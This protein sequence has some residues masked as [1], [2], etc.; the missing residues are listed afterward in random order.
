M[1]KTSFFKNHSH[2]ILLT[3]NQNKYSQL[4]AKQ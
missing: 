1:K 2:L 4:P 3:K